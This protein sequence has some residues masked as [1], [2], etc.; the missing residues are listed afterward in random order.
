ML[1]SISNKYDIYDILNTMIDKYYNSLVNE[2][3]TEDSY[4]NLIKKNDNLDKLCGLVIIV[5]YLE[6]THKL[7]I[8]SQFIIDDL[9]K[10]IDYKDTDN[11]YKK[12]YLYL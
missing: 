6:K 5:G 4:E 8:N 11:L 3:N 9:I 7:N 12:N 10:N 1:N 2:E